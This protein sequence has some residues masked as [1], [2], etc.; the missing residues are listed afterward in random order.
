ML[1]SIKYPVIVCTLEHP[2]KYKGQEARLRLPICK[3][4][5][6]KDGRLLPCNNQLIISYTYLHRHKPTIEQ[7]RKMWW[8]YRKAGL[9]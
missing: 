7:L 4:F 8:K 5:S 9:T 3:F 2:C 6:R 1:N